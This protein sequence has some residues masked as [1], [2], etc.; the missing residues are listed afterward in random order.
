MDTS[1]LVT[2][3]L[4]RGCAWLVFP[5]PLEQRFLRDGAAQRLLLLQVAGLGSAVFFAGMVLADYF[6]IPDQLSLAVILRACVYGPICLLGV[7]FFT[8]YHWPRLI[9][10]AVAGAGL[11]AAGISIVLSLSSDSPLAVAHLVILSVV[12]VYATLIGRFW[13]MLVMCV[14]IA[15]GHA[16]AVHQ[17]GQWLNGLGLATTLLLLSSMV[18]ALY[19]NYTLE[20]SDRQVYLLD[21]QESS[22]QAELTAAND[23]LALSART[24]PLTGLANRR[25]F[26]DFLAQV[27][28][29]SQAQRS[30]LAVLLIDIDHFKRY[31]DQ[32]GHPAGDR[33]LCE[34]A[35]ALA[36]AVRKTGDLV[37]RWGGEEF[38][39]VMSHA[40]REM[41]Q[42]MAQRVVDAVRQCAAPHGEQATAA[43]PVTVSIGVAALTPWHGET[44]QAL[45]QAADTALYEAKA[46]GRD[47]VVCTPRE[48][49]LQARIKVRA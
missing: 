17:H 12:V 7:W 35:Q 1:K 27:W 16:Y 23:A 36:G 42:A 21:L 38:A 8:R 20:H 45:V 33:C 6:M 40:S 44:A 41:A 49:L 24:D 19:G 14:L 32:H 9:E 11:L 46:R 43:P 25:H 31:N 2:D 26:D 28:A 3:T 10:W 48:G 22:L 5:A 15:A 29:H 30:S 18:F 39:V 34:V 13:P 4:A 47:Q 37:A